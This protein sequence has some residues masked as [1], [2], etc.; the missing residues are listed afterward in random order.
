MLKYL[1]SLSKSP[2]ICLLVTKGKIVILKCRNWED[3]FLTKSRLTTTAVRQINITYFLIPCT[4]KRTASL[5][6]CSSPKCI[7][8]LQSWETSD[9]PKLRNIL[10]N[11]WHLLLKL[12]RSWNTG[13]DWKT[14]TDRKDWDRTTKCK[15][16]PEPDPEA[17][18]D[19]GG[20]T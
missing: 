11:N 18:K 7:T 8:S 20:K 6:E 3:I 14:I 5:L 2:T 15:W 4:E 12:S 17:E 10:Q 9:K 13:E 16:D 1:H 19:N